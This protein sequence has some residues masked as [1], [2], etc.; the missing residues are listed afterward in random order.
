MTSCTVS[1]MASLGCS[2]AP[3]TA[4]ATVRACSRTL[5]P[6]RTTLS[7]T[8]PDSL[9]T[10]PT[11]KPCARI[12]SATVAARPVVPVPLSTSTPT[13]D[14]GT[15]TVVPTSGAGG[16]AASGAG[17]GSPAGTSPAGAAGS[18]GPIVYFSGTSVPP[19]TASNNERVP[20][21]SSST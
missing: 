11:V 20:A 1:P 8:V 19:M 17:G 21:P 13:E 15:V 14:G 5:G 9:P 3:G 10:A 2:T 12:R 18:S 6:Y 4:A 7:L 16:C